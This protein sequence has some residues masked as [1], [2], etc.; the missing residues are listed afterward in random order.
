MGSVA[1][2]RKTTGGVGWVASGLCHNW[3]CHSHGQFGGRS[4]STFGQTG[5][6]DMG[7]TDWNGFRKMRIFDSSSGHMS[8][9]KS[10]YGRW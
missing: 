5:I 6:S 1:I 9:T 3:K 2:H 7:R 8:G 10:T 4:L